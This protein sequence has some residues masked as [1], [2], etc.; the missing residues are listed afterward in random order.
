MTGGPAAA[1]TNTGKAGGGPLGNHVLSEQQVLQSGI[2]YAP[3]EDDDPAFRAAVAAITGGA[4][5]YFD[6]RAGTPD[7]ATLQ[8]YHCVYTW[9]NSAFADNVLFGDRLANFVDSGGSVVLGAFSAYTTGNYLSGAI[10]GARVQPG[11]R[12]NQSFRDLGVRR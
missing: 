3:S 8:G 4:V 5:D 2:L 12:R 1:T 10:M 7:L 11:H 6:A 9:A